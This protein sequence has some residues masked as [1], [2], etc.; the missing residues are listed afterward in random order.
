[1][2]LPSM[3]RKHASYHRHIDGEIPG[4]DLYNKLVVLITPTKLIKTIQ[5]DE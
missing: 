5:S 1:M 2:A 4:I 3:T